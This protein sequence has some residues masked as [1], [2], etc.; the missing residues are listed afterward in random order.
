MG[1]EAGRTAAYSMRG[2]GL[3]VSRVQKG[4]Y[5]SVAEVEVP[6][7]RLSLGLPKGNLLCSSSYP[8]S[9]LPARNLLR[10]PGSFL[11]PADWTKKGAV[12][13]QLHIYM[14]GNTLHSGLPWR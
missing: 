3:I 10:T 14:L 1:M 4:R 8:V 7:R 9:D 5:A 12:E 11:S 6:V 13:P 2:A